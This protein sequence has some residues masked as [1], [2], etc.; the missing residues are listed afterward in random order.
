MPQFA[1]NGKNSRSMCIPPQPGRFI[2]VLLSFFLAPACWPIDLEIVE[3]SATSVVNA[4][5]DSMTG[6]GP[7]ETEFIIGGSQAT[8]R[9]S[10]TNSA[11]V[12]NL[13]VESFLDY[14]PDI[15]I[16]NG[17]TLRFRLKEP[18][19]FLISGT[20]SWNGFSIEKTLTSVILN[21]P[22]AEIYAETDSSQSLMGAYFLDRK[23]EGVRGE[24]RGSR[25]GPLKEGDYTLFVS[26]GVQELEDF[27]LHDSRLQLQAAF[28]SRSA[29]FHPR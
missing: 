6:S 27:S 9:V 28:N 16:G 3:G 7:L 11:D 22:D 15:A 2:C 4:L 24:A 8:L 25:A 21:G 14:G 20:Q 5:T 12:F 17:G 19:Y 13:S 26:Y 18:A 10:H 29:A 1:E 23:G